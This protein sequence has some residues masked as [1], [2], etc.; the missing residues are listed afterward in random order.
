MIKK[1]RELTKLSEELGKLINL[2]R[3]GENYWAICPFHHEKTASFMINDKKALFYCFGCGEHGDLFSFMQKFHKKSFSEVLKDYAMKFGFK[4]KEIKNRSQEILELANVY[5]KS[6]LTES[7]KDYLEKRNINEFL[8]EKYEL[9]FVPKSLYYF[10][11]RGY[12]VEELIEAGIANQNGTNL[13]A[14]RISFPIFDIKGEIIAF[15]GRSLGE[16]LPKYINSPETSRF[17]KSLH[18]F[19]QQN[20]CEKPV[21]LVEGYLDVIALHNE[22]D[23]VSVATMGTAVSIY[24]L[25]IILNKTN[26]LYLIFDA[27]PAGV[28]ATRRS[29]YLLLRILTPLKSVYILNLP[30]QLDP[31]DF[32][33][34]LSGY[35]IKNC[36]TI[37]LQEWLWLHI[38]EQTQKQLEINTNEIY[39]NPTF[40]SKILQEINLILN[41]IVHSEVRN[42]FYLFFNNKVYGDKKK[43]EKIPFNFSV[44]K[45]K[46][47]SLIN[48]LLSYM[49]ILL[50]LLEP[51]MAIKF[52]TAN[53]ELIRQFIID[54]ITLEEYSITELQKKVSERF[55]F[56]IKCNISEKFALQYAKDILYNLNNKK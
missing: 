34:N 53:H 54:K 44:I 18:L 21:I 29:C 12:R 45:E 25:K 27:D 20:L 22:K 31:K 38:I 33:D 5:Y 30:W 10:F 7:A 9:G 11:E 4:F 39:T 55:K 19:N 32:I 52:T 16:Q 6:Q 26:K 15:A 41:N 35:D 13:L 48:I 47:N 50:E 46:E 28:N 51:L 36:S 2:K 1:I 17:Q 42:A 37:T 3:T 43:I 8:I 49:N 24:Q 40:S 14:Q 23:F 56:T